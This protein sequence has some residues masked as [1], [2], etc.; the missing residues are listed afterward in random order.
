MALT[1]RWDTLGAAIGARA[2]PPADHVAAQPQDA[3]HIVSTVSDPTTAQWTGGR[4]L[5][6]CLV[7]A[8]VPLLTCVPGE[9]FLP[10]LDA[11]Y[12]LGTGSDVPRLITTRH[13]AAAANMAEAAGKLTGRSAVCFV[14]RGPGA[15]HASIALHT[16]FQ[17]GTPLL[18]VVGQVARPLLGRQAFQEMDYSL[19]FGSSAKSVVQIHDPD[20][21]PEHVA[22]AIQVAHTGRPGPVVLV[23][24][25]DVF[26]EATTSRPVRAPLPVDPP[27]RLQDRDQLQGLLQAARQPVLIVGGPGWT[28]RVGN[29]I[30]RFAEQSSFPV[31]AAFRWQDAVDN[32]SPAFVGHLG[33]GCSPRLRTRVDEA[34]LVVAFGP[35]L[36]DPTTDGFAL[37]DGRDRASLVLVSQDP[38]VTSTAVAGLGIHTGLASAAAYLAQGLASAPSAREG[39]CSELRDEYLAFRA[40]PAQPPE[41][42]LAGI[43]AHVRS[44]LPDDA[45]V[46]NGAGNYTIW[47]QRHF[48]FR[49]FPTQLAPRNGAMGYGLPAGLA[50]AA[51]AKGRTVVTFVGDGCLLMSGSELATAVQFGLKVI[52]I[53]INNAMFGTIRMHQELTYPGRVVATQLRNPDFAAYAQSFGV[54]GTVVRR[55]DDFP[56]AFAD[57]LQHDGPSLIEVRT[58]PAQLTPDYRLEALR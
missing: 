31:V 33:L 45:V 56:R 19:V 6:E 44:V 24:P 54:R 25:E 32:R 47:L 35:R 40:G 16:A 5:V 41:P 10:V 2:Y 15:T 27:D 48:E 46:T 11:L 18:L 3:L 50:A 22:D 4:L 20:R 21:I 34:D 55:T 23:V 57:A 12:D 1:S 52:V 13:E 58:D 17:D 28:S 9:S 8:R 43:V 30:R 37:V 42:D 14:T 53:L 39:W 29:D 7:A 26:A 36:D 49:Q 38:L 51:L